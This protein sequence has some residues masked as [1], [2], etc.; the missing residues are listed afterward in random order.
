MAKKRK[1]KSSGNLM[2]ML[3]PV[4]I[5]VIVAAIFAPRLIHKCDDCTKTFFGTGYYDG[6]TAEAVDSAI[7]TLTGIFGGTEEPVEQEFDEETILCAEC[8]VKIE[9]HPSISLGQHTLDEFKR[10]L[11]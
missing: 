3:I 9:H 7:D 5:V 2:K 6:S 8:A 10:P 4:V 11:F 1:K